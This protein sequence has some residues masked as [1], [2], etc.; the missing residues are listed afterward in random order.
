MPELR[1][2]FWPKLSPGNEDLLAK[3]FVISCASKQGIQPRGC[4]IALCV[5]LQTG[6]NLLSAPLA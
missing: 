1:F 5:T 3:I 6:L 2:S 4:P